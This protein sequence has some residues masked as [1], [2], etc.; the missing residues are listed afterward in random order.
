MSVGISWF[1]LS[2]QR[3]VIVCTISYIDIATGSLSGWCRIFPSGVDEL[4]AVRWKYYYFVGV[5][6]IVETCSCY[7]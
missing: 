3:L 5:A 6:R 2:R 1:N 7:R 4:L